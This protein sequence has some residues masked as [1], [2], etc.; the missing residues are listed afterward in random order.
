MGNIGQHYFAWRNQADGGNPPGQ[1]PPVEQPPANPP[2]GP[3]PPIPPAG[4]PMD[5]C[6]DAAESEFLMIL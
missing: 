5:T 3:Q 1:Q 2:G 4:T 6:L